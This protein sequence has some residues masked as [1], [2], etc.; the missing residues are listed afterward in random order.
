MSGQQRASDAE[1][2]APGDEDWTRIADPVERRR[3]QNRN[4]QRKF[5]KIQYLEGH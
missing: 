2:L 4:A 3:V 1:T 5:R